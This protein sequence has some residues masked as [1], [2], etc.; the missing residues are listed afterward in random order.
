MLQA[1]YFGPNNL[2]EPE[3]AWAAV[4]NRILVAPVVATLVYSNCPNDVLEWVNR[5][6]KWNFTRVIPC[7]FD[8]PIQVRRA[9]RCICSPQA[10]KCHLN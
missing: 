6:S 3:A 1:L 2:L 7:H 10:N 9:C 4:T 5:V 8:G